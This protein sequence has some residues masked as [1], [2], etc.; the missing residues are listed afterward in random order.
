VTLP[1]IGTVPI[2]PGTTSSTGSILP[3]TG[4]TSVTNPGSIDGLLPVISPAAGATAPTAGLV[5]SAAADNAASPGATADP[6]SASASDFVLVVPMATA[7]KIA[8]VILLL[9]VALALR[10]RAK[11]KV[12]PLVFPTRAARG[13]GGGP[14][15]ARRLKLS[16]L[17]HLRRPSGE[18][19]K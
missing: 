8:V 16:S 4:V 14:V 3:P 5:T 1:G 17:R 19:L 12:T 13:A 10:M 11:N 6:T 7:E 2:L 15:P 9:M 18:S